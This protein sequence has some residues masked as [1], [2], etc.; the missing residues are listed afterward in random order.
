MYRP[1]VQCQRLLLVLD[2]ISRHLKERDLF[3][4]M[5]LN[6]ANSTCFSKTN[7]LWPPLLIWTVAVEHPIVCV[8]TRRGVSFN[9]PLVLPDSTLS[10]SDYPLSLPYPL[11][12]P[13]S[14]LARYPF[15]PF[16]H[17]SII[18]INKRKLHTK[19][20]S[21]W[22]P[23][24]LNTQTSPWSGLAVRQEYNTRIQLHEK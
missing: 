12:L 9:I 15:I 20:S 2:W 8:A 24:V 1:Q 22:V 17:P 5:C 6:P 18:V 21:D 16:L 19:F 11:L 13:L 23:V 10:P 3:Q 7:A 14:A 4:Y